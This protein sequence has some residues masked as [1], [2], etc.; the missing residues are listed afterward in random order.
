LL[1][2]ASSAGRDRLIVGIYAVA[3]TLIGVAFIVAGRVPTK[4]DNLRIETVSAAA[5]SAIEK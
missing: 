2:V 1:A 5:A 4:S 3:T